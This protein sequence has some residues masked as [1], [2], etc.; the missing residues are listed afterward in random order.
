MTYKS[1]N[2]LT[3]FTA[4]HMMVN[5][6]PKSSTT[7]VNMMF[8]ESCFYSAGVCR[9]GAYPYFL[10]VTQVVISD[11]TGLLKSRHAFL[12]FNV[13]PPFILDCLQ[14]ILVYY[15]LWYV[16]QLYPRVLPV[17]HRDAIVEF[18]DVNCENLAPGVDTALLNNMLVVTI[19]THCVAVTLSNSSLSPPTPRRTRWVY[20]FCGL[21]SLTMRPYL[22]I[23]PFGTLPLGM[24]KNVLFPFCMRVPM[25]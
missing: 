4:S 20:V 12:Y 17:A 8:L 5:L 25:P 11:L 13:D 16:W 7:R 21:I 1:S 15:L 23:L 24:K 6:I 19:P 2:A 18:L 9:T 22:V 10:M 3:S 14:I